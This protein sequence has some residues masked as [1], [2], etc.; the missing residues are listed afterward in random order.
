MRPTNIMG[1]TKRI[2]EMICQITAESNA[3]N[4]TI[5]MVRFGNVL[6]S[7]GSVI[8]TFQKQIQKGGPITLTHPNITRY[9]MTIDEA[10]QLVIQAA[11]MAESGDLFLLDMG[12]PI[13]IYDLAERLI[14]L[15]GKTVK[16]EHNQNDAGAIE[17]KITGLRSGEKLYEELLVDADALPTEHT[18]IM[19]AREQYINEETLELG[20]KSLRDALEEND[21]IK[22]RTLLKKV[23]VGYQPKELD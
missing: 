21:I 1:A 6:G 13:K 15:S 4:T 7:S 17:I 10:A 8:P 22:F 19:R 9:F 11:G 16:Q 18:K 12:T 5:S 23:V 20:L 2:A 14:R 3:S